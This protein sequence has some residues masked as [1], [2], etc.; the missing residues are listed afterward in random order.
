MDRWVVDP[1][2]KIHSQIE[3]TPTYDLYDTR[4]TGRNEAVAVFKTPELAVRCAALF[5]EQD[6]KAEQARG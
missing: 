5:N 1:T 3:G 6:R 4:L 2:P